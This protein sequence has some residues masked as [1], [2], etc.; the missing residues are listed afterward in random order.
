MLK[1]L[2]C[3]LFTQIQFTKST[4]IDI[5]DLI[6]RSEYKL[7]GISLLSI[8]NI[9]PINLETKITDQFVLYLD[10]SKF[11]DKLSINYIIIGNTPK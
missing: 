4:A 7:M 1:T 5:M 11:V 3:N 2:I 6:Y 9:G 10:T 8:L